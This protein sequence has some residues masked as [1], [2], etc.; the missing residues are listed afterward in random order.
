MMHDPGTLVFRRSRFRTTLILALVPVMV[1]AAY[2]VAV[3]APDPFHRAVGWL[4]VVFFGAGT[5]PL[6]H[7]IWKGGIELTMD[8]SGFTYRR[9]GLGTVPWTEVTDCSET[10]IYGHRILCFRLRNADLH[11]GLLSRRRRLEHAL[12]QRMGYGDVCISFQA[13]RPGLEEAL[14]FIRNLGTIPMR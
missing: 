11:F 8:A 12:N 10:I 3:Q 1:G 5:F 9:S 13:L 4:G 14:A 7:A 2:F 6:L